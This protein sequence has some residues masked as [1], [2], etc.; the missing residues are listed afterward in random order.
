M[1]QAQQCWRLKLNVFRG[2]IE[3]GRARVHRH[4]RPK[5]VARARLA[6]G[7]RQQAGRGLAHHANLRPV[8]RR[9]DRTL[10]SLAPR[11]RDDWRRLPHPR[12]FRDRIG[13]GGKRSTIAE[14]DPVSGLAQGHVN[15]GG[16]RQ[17]ARTGTVLI[18]YDV[19][20]PDKKFGAR[21]PRIAEARDE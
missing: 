21:H 15:I 19:L 1:Q 13:E 16:Q 3:T 14:F 9:N 20:R 17:A 2:T 11:A 4:A 12:G 7:F 8:D 6:H 18:A 10:L 5:T